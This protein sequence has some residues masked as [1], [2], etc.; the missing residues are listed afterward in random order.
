MPKVSDLFATY[1]VCL[2]LLIA[3]NIICCSMSVQAVL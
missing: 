2:N 1:Y 3:C